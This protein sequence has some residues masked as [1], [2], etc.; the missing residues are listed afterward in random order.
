VNVLL[1]LPESTGFV[2]VLMVL[3]IAGAAHLLVIGLK[4][5]A[6]RLVAHGQLDRHPK[7][8]SIL[9]LVTSIAVFSI[10][11]AALGYCLSEFGISMTTYF[12][13]ATVIGLAVG[14]GSQGLVQDVVTGLTLVFSDLIDV[15]DMVEISGQ[16]GI[17]RNIGMRFV[18]LENPMG[19]RVHIPNR[20]IGNVINYPKGYIRCLIDITLPESASLRERMKEVCAQ[21]VE[22]ASEQYPGILMAPASI[23]GVRRTSRGKE[24]L[25]LKFRIWPGRGGPLETVFK[26]DLV[27]ALREVESS[28]AEWMVAVLYE[29][30][31]AIGTRPRQADR[32]PQAT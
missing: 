17:V 14:F 5:L 4:W 20:S 26:Q 15:G 16:T 2:R 18:V 30:E 23:E 6:G 31:R 25:R 7:I 9:G 21:K 10:Y 29:T 3:L 12:A 27:N 22:N 8:R 11:F 13:S 32:P 28:F 24:F 1:F 19:A